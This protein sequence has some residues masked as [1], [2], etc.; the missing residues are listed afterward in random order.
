M[1]KIIIQNVDLMST[2][3]ESELLQALIKLNVEFEIEVD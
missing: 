3:K 2:I 1:K